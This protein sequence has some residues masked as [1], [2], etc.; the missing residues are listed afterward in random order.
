MNILEMLKQAHALK[1]EMGKVNSGLAA[2]ETEGVAGGGLVRVRMDGQMRV[3]SVAIAP[4]LLARGDAA[5]LGDMVCEA[6][7]RAREGAQRRAAEE[8]KKIVGTIPLP[9]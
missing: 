2:I 1:R 7:N 9:L 4:E 5:A 6:A 8:M 3:K